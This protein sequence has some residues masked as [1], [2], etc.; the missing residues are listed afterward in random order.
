MAA[1]ALKNRLAVVFHIV[2]WTQGL[3]AWAVIVYLFRRSYVSATLM[4]L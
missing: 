4:V 2:T 1:T 3:W